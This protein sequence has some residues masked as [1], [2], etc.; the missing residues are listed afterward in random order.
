M[1]EASIVNSG[2]VSLS[3]ALAGAMTDCMSISLFLPLQFPSTSMS[4]QPPS[5]QKEVVVW[6]MY[7]VLDG[8]P[9]HRSDKLLV[10]SRGGA[11]GMFLNLARFGRTRCHCS[12]LDI[13]WCLRCSARLRRS[14]CS[15]QLTLDARQRFFSTQLGCRHHKVRR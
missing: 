12:A 7:H 5:S 4:I 13:P 15:A 14:P 2:T 3:M 8:L 11:T 10:T 6:S 1:T 9:R